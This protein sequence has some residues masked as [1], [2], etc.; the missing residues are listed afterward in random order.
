MIFYF[1]MDF[2]EFEKTVRTINSKQYT[3]DYFR[4]GKD[5]KLAVI[6]ICMLTLICK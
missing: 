4:I 5:T 3:D 6:I 2:I 1:D